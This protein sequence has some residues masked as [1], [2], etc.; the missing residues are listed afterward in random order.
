MHGYAFD[1]AVTAVTVKKNT[2]SLWSQSKRKV[3]R[4]NRRLAT[5]YICI[6][7][8]NERKFDSFL[9]PDLVHAIAQ[10]VSNHEFKHCVVSLS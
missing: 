5:V 6:W 7:R 8:Q 3:R 10:V 4:I 9:F 2:T 1:H